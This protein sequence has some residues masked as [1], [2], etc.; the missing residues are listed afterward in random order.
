MA[1]IKRGCGDSSPRPNKL[2]RL[3]TFCTGENSLDICYDDFGH[4]LRSIVPDARRYNNLLAF[5]SEDDKEFRRIHAKII[6]TEKRV[7]QALSHVWNLID[8]VSEQMD[9]IEDN[10]L[11]AAATS[12]PHWYRRG[13]ILGKFYGEVHSQRLTSIRSE[14]RTIAGNAL[15]SGSR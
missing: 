3:S 9:N 10:E 7:E 6:K 2:P 11:M 1:G 15:L 13:K 4:P 8:S 12:G 14:P 5:V